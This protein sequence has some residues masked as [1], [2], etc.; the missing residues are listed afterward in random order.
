MK[1]TSTGKLNLHEMTPTQE[2]MLLYALYAPDSPAYFEQF[3]YSYRGSLNVNA[4]ASA[5]EQIVNR[6]AILRASFCW[7]NDNRPRQI[8][9][10]H[11]EL[12]F[13]FYDWS[14]YSAAGQDER[15]T[16][17]LTQDQQTGLDLAK[18][19]LIRLA[20]IRICEDDFRIIISNHHLVLDG[21][22]MGIF[23][24]EV[25]QTYQALIRS[26]HVD[27]P[28]PPDFQDYVAWLK[29]E[30]S[31]NVESF[32]RNQLSGFSAPNALPIDHTPARLPAAN[33]EF[34]EQS[35]ALPSGLSRRLQ[36]RARAS[37]VT[38]STM[39][40][41]AWAVLLSRYCNSDDV[42]FG[43]TVAG[44]PYDF[45]EVDSMVGL[46]IN[47]L[48]LRVR[49]SPHESAASCLQKIQYKAAEIREYET[50]SFKQIHEWS[51]VRHNHIPLFESLVVFENFVGHDLSLNLGGEIELMSSHLA[52]TNYPLTLL[53][54]PDEEIGVRAIYHRSRF[55]D[56]AIKRLL[57]HFVMIL[58]SFTDGTDQPIASVN[59]LTGV[60]RQT[61]LSEWSGTAAA[62]QLEPVHRSIEA[63]AARIPD[64]IAVEH[65]EHCL[66]YVELNARANQLAHFL[67]SQGVVSDSL[68][69]ICL[70]RSL[71]MI[72]T[73]LAVLKAGGAY[74][75]LDPAY[76]KDRLGLMLD[77][78][79][80]QLLLTRENL[81][82]RFPEFGGRFIAIEGEANAIARESV[83]N[84]AS[85]PSMESLAYV[86]YTSGST[87]KPKGV[88][89]EHRALANF[90]AGA[91]DEYA[92]K[93][94]DRVLQFASLC[95]DAS[96]EEIYC[97]LSRG[98]TLVL[99]TDAM[100]TSP[101]QFLQ[102]SE[103]LGITVLDLPTGY[104]HHLAVAMS[105][106]ELGTPRSLRLVIMG[107]EQ[108]QS[109]HVARWVTQTNGKVRLLNTYGPTEATVVTT[110][111]DL[112]AYQAGERIAIGRPLPGASVY[113][114]DE[115]L[116]PVP[117]GLS[118]ELHIGGASVARGYLNQPELTAKKFVANPLGDGRLYRSGDVVRF[119]PDGNLE[120]LGRVDNQV[121]IRGFRI[122]LEE[123][124]QSIRAHDAV[125]DAV[126]TVYHDAEGDKRLCAY[127]VLKEP[128]GLAVNDLRS[129]LKT[130]LP[131][132]MVPG[133]WMILDG[134]PLMPN[135]KVDRQA[136]SAPDG[137]RP[138]VEADFI[139]PR[140]PTEELLAR[141]WCSVLK[142]DQVGINDNFFELGGHSLLAARVFSELQ[143][144]LNL[145]LSLVDIF[146]APTIA[147]L[148]EMIYQRETE[149]EQGD[150]LISLLSELD[151][152]S[153]EQAS[154]RLAEELGTVSP[155][156]V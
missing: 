99:R 38:M 7:D 52:R 63:Q 107:G 111:S 30:P 145:E 54:N 122:E 84:P 82:D 148:A 58:E 131:A 53:I 2:A 36:D 43:I 61:L 24:R 102:T 112:S 95:F 104:W 143:R 25:S 101:K 74:V 35:I 88:M 90:A 4:L 17:F 66:T 123:I 9:Q 73:V 72:V 12:P 13:T 70:E 42:L 144:K 152:L 133:S 26:E 154:H 32:W 136:L 46:L 140:T 98:A 118:G 106:D 6:H 64:A 113:V 92:I 41:A 3:C 51:D 44:R 121:K 86:I 14:K 15:L 134:L 19:P 114:L 59:L 57:N 93:P 85:N 125:S 142:L 21:W 105:A 27:L 10:D 147:E 119:L 124:E 126:V 34:D 128:N 130:G 97:T 18:A 137:E 20:V 139:A 62:P 78:S 91:S 135:G 116:Q 156:S 28:A 37:R 117:V 11:V 29:R 89:I 129:F 75:P 153:D 47:T 33:E 48:P 8:V 115:A 31:P 40:Q 76:P 39:A 1:M 22:S 55:E 151:E 150:A 110:T 87:G 16:A 138:Q 77:D 45:P 79:G 71:D 132:H 149:H 141:I 56:E 80:A 69:G 60:E 65:E 120:F 100:L 108:A 155:A 146:S 50:T 103:A 127:V 94:E 109:D 67:I 81:Q 96:A 23:R 83:E 5:C 68:V 49:L